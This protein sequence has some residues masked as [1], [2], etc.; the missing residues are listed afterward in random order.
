MQRICVFGPVLCCAV[1]LWY[2]RFLINEWSGLWAQHTSNHIHLLKSNSISFQQNHTAQTPDRPTNRPVLAFHSL[3][4]LSFSQT[5]S[6]YDVRQRPAY[7]QKAIISMSSIYDDDSCAVCTVPM[8]A[9]HSIEAISEREQDLFDAIRYNLL[10]VSCYFRHA[11]FFPPAALSQWNGMFFVL[12]FSMFN[13]YYFDTIIRIEVDLVYVFIECYWHFLLPSLHWP[14]LPLHF[15]L[16]Y[17]SFYFPFS[18]FHFA[19]F[20]CTLNIV[21]D[22][23]NRN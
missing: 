23:S 6:R 7:V 17:F 22:H 4:F 2:H 15:S 8:C 11:L 3:R 14:T 10:F 19:L 18:H 12:Y 21:A 5:T 1:N 16:F 20:F 13:R 9:P